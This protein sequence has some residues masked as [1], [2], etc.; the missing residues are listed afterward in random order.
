MQMDKSTEALHAHSVL[1]MLHALEMEP[2]LGNLLVEGR[3]KECILLKETS[4]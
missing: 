2:V 3:H 4:L 1:F